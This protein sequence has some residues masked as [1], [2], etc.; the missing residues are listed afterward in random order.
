[1]HFPFG[2]PDAPAKLLEQFSLGHT[3][4]LHEVFLLDSVAWM[5]QQV[6]KFPVVGDQDQALAHPIE[7]ADG[8]QPSLAWYEINHPRATGGVKVRGHHSHRLIEHV[9]HPLRVG[10]PLA[11]DTDFLGARVDPRA[12]AGD[13]L[14]VNLHPAAGDEFLAGSAAAK[15]RRCQEFLEPLATIIG[16]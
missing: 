12:K 3:R 1:M 8:K 5:G 9:D 13:D 10:E 4:H 11:I 6:G 7:P 2:K 16:R 15:A 14:A